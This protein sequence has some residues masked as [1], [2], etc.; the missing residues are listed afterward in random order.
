MSE[1]LEAYLG[2]MSSPSVRDITEKMAADTMVAWRLISLASGEQVKDPDAC[3]GPDGQAFLFWDAKVHH[4]EVELIP[5]SP[6]ELFY[7]NRE[8]RESWF[9]EW[10]IGEALPSRFVGYLHL[11]KKDTP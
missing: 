10:N 8:T 11:F 4:L 3:T 2:R 1:S 9:D 5:D 6:T 7:C